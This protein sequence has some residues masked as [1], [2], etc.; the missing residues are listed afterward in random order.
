LFVAVLMI[1]SVG[2][3]LVGHASATPSSPAVP[4][5]PTSP[6]LSGS[7][8]PQSGEASHGSI[9]KVQGTF[10]DTNSTFAPPNYTGS[11]CGQTFTS[12]NLS[13]EIINEYYRTC[14]AGPQDPSSVS[15][16]GKAI[17]VAYSS[18]TNDTPTAACPGAADLVVNGVFFQTSKNAGANWGTPVG[19]GNATCSYLQAFDPSVAISDGTIYAA[20]VETNESNATA[21]QVSAEDNL[22][23]DAIGFTTST[24]NGSSFAP[25]VSLTTAGK[26]NLTDP[27][28]AAFGDSVYVV[29]VNTANWTN[30][31]LPST[32]P[33]VVPYYPTSIDLLF[34]P[35][36]GTTWQGPFGLPG[37]NATYG[38][39]ADGPSL[40]VNSLG[41]LAVSYATDLSCISFSGLCYDY[42]DSIVVVTSMHNGTTWSAPVTVDPVTGA[43]ACQYEDPLGY[44]CLLG[45]E[46]G[47]HS[48]IAFAPDTPS[49]IY[50]VYTGSYYTW[51]SSTGE[52]GSSTTPNIGYGQ[53]MYE[54]VSANTG[55]TWTNSI[56]E[57]TTSTSDYSF[58]AIVNPTIEV[59][60]SGEVYVAFAWLNETSCGGCNAAFD[61]Y[62]SYWMGYSTNGGSTWTLYPALLTDVYEF[63]MEEDW[64]GLTTALTVTSVG[65]VSVYGEGLG[66]VGT[67]AETTGSTGGI[68]TYNYWY[69]YSYAT[70]LLAVFPSQGTPLEVNFTATGLP[71]K[72][73]WGFTLSGNVFNSN[74]TTIQVTNVPYDVTLTYQSGVVPLAYWTQY[75]GI[76]SIGDEVSFLHSGNVS[77]AYSIYYGVSFHLSPIAP[78]N[79][80]STGTA[81][82]IL[83]FEIEI[84][85]SGVYQYWDW[86]TEQILGTWYN[87]SESSES[88]PWYFPSGSS[89]S[90]STGS[91][92]DIYTDLPL[93][94]IY[95]DGNG[96]WTGVYSGAVATI[97]GPINETYFAGA[98][99]SYDL[100][101]TPVG[102]PAGSSYSFQFDGTSYSGTAPAAV[103]VPNVLTGAYALSDVTASSTSPG[104]VY[105]APGAA[106][107]VEVPVQTDIVLNFTTE[108]D[109]TGTLGIATF[110]ASGLADGDFWQLLFNGTTYGSTTPW[111]NV[112]THPGTYGVASLPITASAND[113]TAY[114]A[115][116]FGPSLSVVPGTTYPVNFSLSYRV[117]VS[118][119][120]GGTATGLG[121]HW[122]APGS[123]GSYAAA[124]S[125]GYTFLGWAGGG[126]GSYTG[127]SAYANITVN[128]PISE[129]ATFEGLPTDRFNLTLTETGLPSGTWWTVSLNHTGYSSDAATFQVADLSSCSAGASGQYA[130]SVPYAFLNGTS[131]VRYVATAYPA[132]TC[133]DGLTTVT[134]T[135]QAE[136][137]VTTDSSVGGSAYVAV[138]GPSTTT[139]AWVPSGKSISI[140][141]SPNAG[142]VFAGWLGTGPGSSSGSLATEVVTP[143][144][145]VTEVATFQTAPVPYVPVYTVA[146]QLVST[147]VPGT[148]WSLSFNGTTYSS[149]SNGI[150]ISGLPP[151]SYKLSIATAYSPDRTAEYLP[152]SVA[153]TVDLT[154]NQTI[155][156]AY[157]T[158]YW[159]T[160]QASAGG[161]VA[162]AQSGY[163]ASGSLVALSATPG[164]GYSFVGWVG[165]GP[166]SYTGTAANGNATVS[167]VIGETASFA[168]I[169]PSGG[170]SSFLASTTGIVVLAIVGLIVGLAVGIVVFRNR[171]PKSGAPDEGTGGESA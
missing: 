144:G 58:D 165:T 11:P 98:L 171:R 51:N 153:S 49:R 3:A 88:F 87:G 107:T 36:G 103:S 71:S 80:T 129:A 17:G 108:V 140:G 156:V 132:T 145:P 152:H 164:V 53:A 68:P 60:A 7:P 15:L 6:A 125:T 55:V 57:R 89:L 75:Q 110:Q 50:V 13:T 99:G 114:T 102:L 73:V 104:Y 79:L 105:Y 70:N 48:S 146:F 169:A 72:Y 39:S 69:N 154:A 159:V 62:T 170:S 33:P 96:S 44:H 42:G 93:S 26:D 135:F 112:T 12:L 24:D 16:G 143:T 66:E 142:Y 9:D 133:T 166:G 35:D 106:S 31:T 137:L 27:Q 52:G 139:S 65:P 32:S 25:V 121:L 37:E 91:N 160:V 76:S 161:T 84:D 67:F 138:G 59:A 56:V 131:G 136:Y 20:F 8:N 151:G 63:Y 1:V 18:I 46:Q 111:I 100:S 82:S 95:G 130:L 85:I 113:S 117:D 141:A 134:I 5:S 4:S 167:G 38:Y 101:F 29:Y 90:L 2:A 157:S 119:S 122:L 150:N 77:I 162:P 19:I 109:T 149:T 43:Y 163:Y 92:V 54:A 28:V 41:E 21:P 86:Y 40:A 30:T 127:T 158:S 74:D 94:Y 148:S 118:S 115:S 14:Q 83:E 61:D 124:A 64:Y 168:L 81:E 128:A 116:A 97:N 34:S 123:T 78:G 120:L 45:Y 22:S 10:F 155:Q 23:S 147:L 126:S 47:P